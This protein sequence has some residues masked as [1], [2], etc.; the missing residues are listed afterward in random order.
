MRS[1][2]ARILPPLLLGATLVAC[3]GEDDTSTDPGIDPPDNGA[4]QSAARSVLENARN[5]GDI[6]G[7]ALEIGTTEAVYARFSAGDIASTD[8]AVFIAS[9]GKPVAAAVI[10]SL[11]NDAALLPGNRLRLDQPIADYLDG[12]PAGETQAAQEITLRQ[13]LNHTSGLD[14]SP[15]CV[16]VQDRS[17]SSD[18]LM[19]CATAILEDGTA[20]EPGNEFAY[21]AGG[22]QV[23]GAVAEAFAEQDWQTLVDERIAQPLGVSLPFLP[24]SNPRIAG[25]IRASTADLAAF[26]RAVLTRDTAILDAD[27]YDMLRESQTSTDGGRLP[28]VT[29]SDYS[30]G[31]WIESSGELADAGTAGPELSSPGLFGTTPWLD[32]DRDYYGVLLLQRSDYVTS[33]EL[34]RELRTEILARLP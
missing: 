2:L 11:T 10:L 18:S 28:G 13:L 20:F 22:Y 24:A 7:Y 5:R 15:D 23:A 27:D 31:F 33:L 21:G 4:L 6:D 25:G 29:A 26:Q 34:M 9:A 3:N 16:S 19:E 12:T 8:G 14:T 32:D 30:F 1:H 17:S